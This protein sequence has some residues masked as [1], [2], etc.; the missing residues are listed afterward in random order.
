MEKAR[1]E[2]FKHLVYENKM[3]QKYIRKA[4]ELADKGK[5]DKAIKY[6][7]LAKVANQCALQAHDQFWEVS[8]GD[9]TTEEFAEYYQAELLYKGIQEVFQRL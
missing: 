9:M 2:V 6:F 1:K 4:I 7:D 3:A 8:N 5:R